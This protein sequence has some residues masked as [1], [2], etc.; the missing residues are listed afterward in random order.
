MDMRNCVALKG[1]PHMETVT[2]LLVKKVNQPE[3][4]AK[5]VGF[6]PESEKS[7][8]IDEKDE[9]EMDKMSR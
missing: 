2:N 6:Y 8:M 5:V 9:M 3:K 7:E 4:P 1:I